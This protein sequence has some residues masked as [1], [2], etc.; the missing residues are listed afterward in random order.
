M[1]GGGGFQDFDILRKWRAAKFHAES[2]GDHA[3]INF[4]GLFREEKVF[5]DFARVFE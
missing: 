5:G 4:L 2:T 1:G 3:E